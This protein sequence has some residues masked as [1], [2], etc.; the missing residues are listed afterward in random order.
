MNIFEYIIWQNDK[1]I[2][3]SWTVYDPLHKVSSLFAEFKIC[4]YL[5]IHRE[6]NLA[7]PRTD[8]MMQVYVF[9]SCF[10]FCCDIGF[11]YDTIMD[12]SLFKYLVV[13]SNT[14][15]THDYVMNRFNVINASIWNFQKRHIYIYRHTFYIIYHI[16]YI[17]RYATVRI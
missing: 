7:H 6:Y 17:C 9:V 8:S 16:T 5:F 13:I 15:V 10:F 14:I 12:V 4:T 1:F 3:Y 2:L 11:V